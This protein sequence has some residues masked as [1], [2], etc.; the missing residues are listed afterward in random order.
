MLSR[1]MQD[2]LNEQINAE[3]YSAYLY[4]AI[5]AYFGNLGLTGS[6]HW[7]SLQ[8]TEELSHAHKMVNYVGERGGRVFLKQIAEPPAEWESPLAAF[9][10]VHEHETKVTGLINKLVDLAHAESDH[11][12]NNFLQWFVAEQVEEEAS[13]EGVVQQLK[14]AGE[15]S[16]GLFMVDREL[17]QRQL[18]LP[19]ELI[20]E[21]K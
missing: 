17:A 12:T 11:A 20:G 3:I 1:K 19:P 14:L 18:V 13:A 10:A 2:A 8:A 6:A 21:G 15:A 7:M 5:R 16:G 9:E 4:Y